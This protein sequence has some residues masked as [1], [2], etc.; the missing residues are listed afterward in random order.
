MVI[1]FNYCNCCWD[2]NNKMIETKLGYETAYKIWHL[3]IDKN[4]KFVL[5]S[6]N[7]PPHP[8]WIPNQAFEFECR[9]KLAHDREERLNQP[10]KFC[11][12]IKGNVPMLGFRESP[13]GDGCGIYSVKY[14]WLLN[15]I[16]MQ[17]NDTFELSISIV[18]QVMIWGYTEEFTNGHKSEFAYPIS[19]DKLIYR[20]GVF[21]EDIYINFPIMK[22]SYLVLDILD[23]LRNTYLHGN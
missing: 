19:I 18:G 22:K 2:T 1:L 5:T 6:M 14:D 9:T 11:S 3:N 16:Y 8:I 13:F 21:P 10:L 7:K 4:S 17:S 20:K 12:G 23:D 15:D